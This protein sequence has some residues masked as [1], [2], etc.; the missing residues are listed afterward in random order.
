MARTLPPLAGLNL[1]KI[2]DAG[3]QLD[4]GRMTPRDEPADAAS[5]DAT[6][7]KAES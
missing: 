7:S 2:G 6:Y 4:A 5:G 1:S 3:V